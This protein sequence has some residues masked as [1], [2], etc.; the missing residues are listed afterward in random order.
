MSR[1]VYIKFGAVTCEGQPRGS[2]D[3][4]VMGAGGITFGEGTPSTIA[5]ALRRLHQNLGH[6][7]GEDLLRHLRLAGCDTAVLKA[8]PVNEMS[9]LRRLCRTQSGKTEHDTVNV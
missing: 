5:T 9:G 2:S 4:P 7:R 3:G 6:P 1:T 8:G